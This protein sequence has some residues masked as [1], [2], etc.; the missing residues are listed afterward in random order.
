M[1]RLRRSFWMRVIAVLL[2]AASSFGIFYFGALAILELACFGVGDWN[3]VVEHYYSSSEYSND[4]LNR[5]LISRGEGDLTYIGQ[6][7]Y[8]T[9]QEELNADQTNF[10]FRVLDPEGNVLYTNAA[11]SWEEEVDVSSVQ[12]R[13]Y[14]V[15]ALCQTVAIQ[16]YLSSESGYYQSAVLD[17]NINFLGS[18]DGFD[19]IYTSLLNTMSDAL[20]ILSHEEDE[21]TLL[22]YGAQTFYENWEI[23]ERSGDT[24][25]LWRLYYLL[26]LE[27]G[28][29]QGIQYE[30][31]DGGKLSVYFD[32]TTETTSVPSPEAGTLE[33]TSED[34]ENG[35]GSASRHSQ[36][37]YCL[38]RL[39][40]DEKLLDTEIEELKNRL[41]ISDGD[42]DE[43]ISALTLIR[44]RTKNA[45]ETFR[46]TDACILEWSAAKTLPVQD[47]LKIANVRFLN[48]KTSFKQDCAFIVAIGLVGLLSLIWLL[49]AGGH[50][51]GEPGLHLSTLEKC[52]QDL[53]FLLTAAAYAVVGYLVYRAARSLTLYELFGQ[54]VAERYL[55]CGVIGLIGTGLVLLTLPLVMG[56]TVQLKEHSFC[57]RTV[58]AAVLRT[59]G[60]GFRW[61][62]RGLSSLVLGMPLAWR[63]GFLYT[64]FCILA[65]FVLLLGISAGMSAVWSDWL[66]VIFAALAALWLA[67]LIVVV[68]WG[69]GW[70]QIQKAGSALAEGDLTYQTD[71][72][73]F[74]REL[75]EHAEHLNAASH[76]VEEAVQEQMRSDRF[77]TELITNVSHDLKTPLTSIINYVD[78]L[79]KLDLQDETAQEYLEVLDRKSQRL[80]TLTEDLVEAS[81]ASAGVLPVN[82][83]RLEA[84]ELLRQ[85]AGEY[86][87]KFRLAHLEL[88]LTTPDHPVWIQADGR[89][90]WRILDNFFSNCTKYAM[91]GTRVYVD[92]VKTGNE[93]QI[94]VKNISADPLNVPAAELMERFVR[95]DSSRTTE[96]SGLGLSIAQSLA[97]LEGAQVRIE[98]DGDL[99][100]SIL[101]FPAVGD[102]ELPAPE[103]DAE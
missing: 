65:A 63:A 86:E 88:K 68:R 44:E 8:D 38:I 22:E 77:R 97:K 98:V 85:A 100:K 64:G 7:A 45:L 99:F 37:L 87:D 40:D 16:S 28:G 25:Y 101:V 80:K 83:E 62:G 74:P 53:L 26:A 95:G 1:K 11:G 75:K 13:V 20:L 36:I 30:A 92:A 73:R 82:A 60:R 9:L 32:E 69:A 81:K 6:Q 78:L 67:G 71:T 10:R 72:A 27:Y 90:T 39:A 23:A 4:A 18:N 91:P 43:W 70:K 46:N 58:L 94:L 48:W 3:S 2:I 96:G 56:T 21:E 55:M 12:R 33:D 102:A 34:T 49:Y 93:V 42:A 17:G 61:V 31:D 103:P 76:I 35:T 50:I 24:G 54:S 5:Y 19:A 41:G 66:P 51:E 52:P 47:G 57:R 59:L 79:K 15:G 84:G 29:I 14:S 89:H